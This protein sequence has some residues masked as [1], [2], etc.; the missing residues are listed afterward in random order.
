MISY[1]AF[2]LIYNEA[3]KIDF[4]TQIRHTH[5]IIYQYLI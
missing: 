1:K 3:L 2:E 5:F 4:L